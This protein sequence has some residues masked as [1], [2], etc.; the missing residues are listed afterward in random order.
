ME[1]SFMLVM[2]RT[3]MNRMKSSLVPSIARLS[4]KAKIATD[5]VFCN[6]STCYCSVKEN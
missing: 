1:K 6:L 5:Y 3:K 2:F 4:A